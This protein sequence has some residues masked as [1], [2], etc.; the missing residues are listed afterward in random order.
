MLDPRDAPEAVRAAAEPLEELLDDN[1][2][3]TS[4]D[5]HD[6]VPVAGL[7]DDQLAQAVYDAG[8]SGFRVGPV[9]W[10]E[11]AGEWREAFRRAV[12]KGFMQP[13]VRYSDPGCR[14]PEELR[15]TGE[16]ADGI[17]DLIEAHLGP[18]RR[19]GDVGAPPT[20]E[21]G[22]RCL[23][24]VTEEWATILYLAVHD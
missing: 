4:V 8:P 7:T 18:V 21:I 6:P 19:C 5:L 23:L 2:H 20:G 14:T 1:N 11:G 24:L 22:W 17:A 12:L 15:R 16:L 9:G 10:F 13:A 3:V